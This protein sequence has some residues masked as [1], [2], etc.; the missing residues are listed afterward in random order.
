[1]EYD[2]YEYYAVDY[3]VP[4]GS[5]LGPLL[6]V[7]FID[8]LCNII[9]F[10]KLLFANNLKIHHKIENTSNECPFNSILR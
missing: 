2:F 9:H 10:L 8:D 7:I 4:P 3:G 1:M 5:N 6:F